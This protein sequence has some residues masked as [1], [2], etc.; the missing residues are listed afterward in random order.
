MVTQ[1]HSS[2]D[3][4]LAGYKAPSPEESLASS[5]EQKH[6]MSG[7]NDLVFIYTISPTHLFFLEKPVTSIYYSIRN[8]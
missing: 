8:T 1:P 6:I 4:G 2:G 5:S 3:D 7:Q